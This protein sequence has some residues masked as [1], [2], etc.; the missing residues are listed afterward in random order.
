MLIVPFPA[1][2]E[3]KDN[4]GTDMSISFIF[5]FP[6]DCEKLRHV[7]PDCTQ[8]SQG[9]WGWYTSQWCWGKRATPLGK[10]MALS[11]LFK[12][13]KRGGDQEQRECIRCKWRQNLDEDLL[14]FL[15]WFE[16]H[17][18]ISCSRFHSL[19]L[20][21]SS[22]VFEVPS[23]PGSFQPVSILLTVLTSKSLWIIVIFSIQER[24]CMA[25]L[26]FLGQKSNQLPTDFS[27]CLLFVFE[28]SQKRKIIFCTVHL[29]TIDRVYESSRN[30]RCI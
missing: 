15:F 27:Y 6:E 5:V 30:T 23:K 25:S 29:G 22:V 16:F 8:S 7:L 18:I 20:F 2:P 19:F 11:G 13:C 24:L 26:E 3:Q 17:F 10:P 14:T 1:Y 12:T 28:I 9:L 4:I 21:L